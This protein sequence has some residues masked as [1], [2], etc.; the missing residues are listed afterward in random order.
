MF[1][2]SIL[3]SEC[4]VVQLNLFVW[5]HFLPEQHLWERASV[6]WSVYWCSQLPLPMPVHGHFLLQSVLT[7]STLDLWSPRS[8][9]IHCWPLAWHR[10]PFVISPLFP[11][12]TSVHRLSSCPHVQGQRERTVKL[13]SFPVCSVVSLGREHFHCSIERMWTCSSPGPVLLHLWPD[14]L[15]KS[16]LTTCCAHIRF[17]KLTNGHSVSQTDHHQR[18]F[19]DNIA[20]EKLLKLLLFNWTTKWMAVCS[21]YSPNA[22]RIYAVEGC[23]G[24]RTAFYH[25]HW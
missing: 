17:S 4:L 8:T 13:P 15:T 23:T 12:V 14:A 2:L 6:H 10:G 20:K 3:E 24:K 18:R 9:H 11:Y 7:E 16:L 19:Y 21:I 22:L 1:S 5:L 25:T